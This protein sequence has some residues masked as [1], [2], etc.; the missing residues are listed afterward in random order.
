MINWPC[1]RCSGAMIV[2]ETLS[3]AQA[4]RHTTRNVSLWTRH[5]MML[6]FTTD[7]APAKTTLYVCLLARNSTANC[8]QVRSHYRFCPSFARAVGLSSPTFGASLQS[9]L[10]SGPVSPVLFVHS[11]FQ[12]P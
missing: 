6:R 4:R 2:I 3:P 12:N 10:Q 1:P 7:M 11:G 9:G 5:S 8:I